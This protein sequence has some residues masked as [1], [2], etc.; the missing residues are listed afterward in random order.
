M[1]NK[2]IYFLGIGGI[3]M[4]ALAQYF[5]SEGAAVYGY[6][7]TPSPI[8]KM[9]E[10]KGAVIHFDDNIQKI[11]QTLDF[12]IYTPAVPRSNAEFQYL[13]EKG[14]LLYKRSQVLG[15]ITER[16]PSIAVAGTH[17]KTTTTSMVSH[18]LSPQVHIVA[19]IGGIAKNFNDN[20]VLA[21][22]PVMAVAEADEYDRSFLTLHPSVAIITAMDADHLDIYGTHEN[23]IAAFQQFARQSKTVIVEENVAGHIQHPNK[24]IYGVG[25]DA[26]YQAY[27]IKLS[28]NSATFDLRTPSGTLTDLQLHANGLYNVLNATAAVAALME[29]SHS[30]G[31]VHDNFTE[32]LIREKLNSFAGVKRRFDYIVDNKK[33]VFIDDYAHHPEEMHSFIM[34][35]RKIYPG[36]HITGIF[37]P[38]LY[39]RTRDFAQDFADVLAPLD[40]VILLPIYP[41][42]EQPIPGIDSEY[43]LSLIDN[44]HKIVL[45]K[46]ELLPYL[47]AHPQEVLLTIG[48]GDID[49]L[50][51]EIGK[52]IAG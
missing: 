34:A 13:L 32:G 46:E 37:Q 38:H 10:E 21:P 29:E 42:R 8:T 15:S 24:R 3:G 35:V 49:R 27:N 47:A 22:Q 19:F 50:V 41:A 12:A 45:Q 36:K 9:L 39:S 52:V 28:P 16:M 2:R 25:S 30:N 14:I 48:A 11:P 5:L 17:G 44:P 26:D 6:D 20:L 4:S 40:Q 7:L 31:P 1:K 23:L 51:P 43:L 33:V 18:L